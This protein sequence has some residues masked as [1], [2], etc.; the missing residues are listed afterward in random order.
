MIN[1]KRVEING[2]LSFKKLVVDIS[3]KNII[4]GA[5]GVWKSNFLKI[6]KKSFEYI[7][8]NTDNNKNNNYSNKA[9]EY[10]KL[11]SHGTNSYI[12]IFFEFND[13]IRDNLINFIFL[14]I[15]RTKILDHTHEYIKEKVVELATK[16]FFHIYFD[17]NN[18][19]F[20]L[21]DDTGIIQ[22]RIGNYIL[23][24]ANETYYSNV[25]YDEIKEKYKNDI[26]IL[27][28]FIKDNNLFY[29]SE[30]YP[31]QLNH[32]HNLCNDILN[33]IQDRVK[34]IGT[35][36]YHNT[37]ENYMTIINSL[38]SIN[39]KEDI[40]D[41]YTVFANNIGY[42]YDV[43]VRESPPINTYGRENQNMHQQ[44]SYRSI[45]NRNYLYKD[46]HVNILK[47]C[48]IDFMVTNELLYKEDLYNQVLND[49]KSITDKEFKIIRSNYQYNIETKITI[50]SISELDNAELNNEIKE[51]IIEYA[52]KNRKIEFDASYIIIK[53][54]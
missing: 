22:L 48:D 39:R 9:E 21:T 36:M 35:N 41:A 7:I 2:F 20:K 16:P 40:F 11:I 34:F 12:K 45:M 31:R 29:I 17:D 18:L 44:L 14:E 5:N 19:R 49:F 6:V 30:E 10:L 4:V 13:D 26:N 8:G 23:F 38:S 28:Q 32:S 50:D 43:Y 52:K 1:I 37:I 33:L 27:K 54:G 46:D 24:E 42:Y 3:K 25:N 47:N 53:N 15:L 51:K